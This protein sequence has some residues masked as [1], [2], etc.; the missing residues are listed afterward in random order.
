MNQIQRAHVERVIKCPACG[1]IPK[2]NRASVSSLRQLGINDPGVPYLYYV[3]CTCRD[4]S[5]FT[6]DWEPSAKKAIK[7]WND[8][9]TSCAYKNLELGWIAVHRC[10]TEAAR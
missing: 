10:E 6:N 5:G 3:F 8:I 7:S 4:A 9:L 2:L 1:K